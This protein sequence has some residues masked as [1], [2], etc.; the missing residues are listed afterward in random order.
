M[1]SAIGFL[2]AGVATVR[3]ARWNGWRRYAPLATGV[4][5]VAMLPLMATPALAAAVTVY[6]LLLLA[7]FVAVVTAP[8]PRP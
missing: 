2:V 1:I 5:M 8:A 3:A 6:G 4:W 7:V